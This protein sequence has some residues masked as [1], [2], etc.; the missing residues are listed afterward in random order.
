M[1][2]VDWLQGA[3]PAFRL[4][5]ATSWLAPDSWR[6]NQERAI[7]EAMA[8]G[9][10]WT[11][12]LSLVVRHQT[13]ALAW[14]ALNRVPE[15]TIPDLAR[16][17]LQKLSDACRIQGMQHS[18]LLADVLKGLNCAGIPAM[19][20][21]GQFL[22]L[23]LYGDLAFAIPWIWIWK[24]RERI[25]AGRKPAWRART[26]I[27]IPLSTPRA[28]ANG[29]ASCATSTTCISYIPLRAAAWNFIGVTTGKLQMPPARGGPEAFPPSGTGV[30]SRL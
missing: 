6:Q 24:W 29:S 11:E 3:S 5:I 28:L 13:P 22:S 9:P 12:F 23:E 2:E 27:S 16:R 30:R 10:D 15:I 8:A 1:P 19:P 4:T 21:K 18:L 7:R 20:L 17:E 25:S 26:G 14:A